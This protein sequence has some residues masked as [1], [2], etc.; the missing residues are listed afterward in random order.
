[1]T[2]GF[3]GFG[4]GLAVHAVALR[5]AL[6]G[7]SWA[8]AAATGLSTLGVAA[9]PLG[10]SSA[11]DLIHGSFA[12][13]GYIT[14]ALTPL[15]AAGPLRRAGRR[16][17]ANRSVAAAAVAGICLTASTASQL[18][19]LFQRLGLTVADLWIMASAVY[20]LRERPKRA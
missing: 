2:V 10:H 5:A 15:L 13:A 19:G 9:A 20:I 6:P 11:V 14:L 18:N 3:V 8:T 7:W 16:T 4:I 12:T 1:M 17:F